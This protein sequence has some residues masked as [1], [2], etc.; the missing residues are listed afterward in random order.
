MLTFARPCQ[1]SPNPVSLLGKWPADLPARIRMARIVS[2]DLETC[3]ND[4]GDA[5]DPWRGE[6]RLFQLDMT[7]QAPVLVDVRAA[8]AP[9][10]ELLAALESTV[11][12]GHN[13]AFDALWLR[14]KWGLR[15]RRVYCTL[16]AS[17]LLHAG[18][19]SVRHDLDSVLQRHLRIQ[20]EGDKQG[21]QKADWGGLLLP[22]MLAYAARDVM[23]L[24]ALGAMINEELEKAGLADVATLEMKLRPAVTEIEA[25]GIAVDRPRLQSIQAQAAADAERHAAELRK[26][27]D[28]PKLN[29]GSPMQLTRALN[30]KG[31]PVNSTDEEALRAVDDGTIIPLILT[32]RAAEK[33]AQQAASLLDWIKSDGRIHGRFDPTGTATG[34]FSSK[35]PNLQNIGRGELRSCFVPAAGCK[36]VVADYSQIE[37]RVAAALARET[38]MIEAYKNGVDLHRQTAAALLHKAAQ[39]VTSAERQLAKASAFGLLY[40]QS[41]PGLVRYAASAYGVPLTLEEATVI[42]R[43]FFQTYGNIRQWHGE[44]RQRAEAGIKEV[45]TVTGR[46]R[47]VPD[48]ASE[49]EGFTALVNTPVQGGAADGMKRAIVRLSRSLPPEALM[50]STVHDELIVEAPQEVAQSVC[51]QVSSAM[52]E[53]MSELFPTVP[54]EVEAHVCANWGEK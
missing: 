4:R 25:A 15:L 33:L 52:R 42:R 9:P 28:A 12:I 49:W 53:A 11:V 13:V 54:I 29:V 45:R 23:H 40:G 43:T 51:D 6:I 48:S 44:S 32:H 14:V 19:R 24:E 39:D 26:L 36:L 34:R 22:D 5:L 7:D 17:R 20:P 8:G 2:L 16:T 1:I 18:D 47:L 31:I 46:R 3:G 21:M 10:P 27:L 50:V 37:L 41:A 38:R 30:G 35:D